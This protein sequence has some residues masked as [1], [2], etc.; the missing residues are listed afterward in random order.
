MSF[1]EYKKTF[2]DKNCTLLITL[3]E[4]DQIKNKK[5]IKLNIISSCGHN[6]SVHY[7]VFK[8]RN[9]GVLCPS[10]KGK[11]TVEKKKKNNEFDKIDGCSRN[12]VT[13]YNGYLMFKEMINELYYIKKTFD[14]CIV[15]F[16]IK[17]K[18]LT[19]INGYLFK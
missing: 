5:N 19:K 4:F 10:C 17:K 8:H 11:E 7:N 14:G 6:H 15:D 18:M 1:E 13:E 9:S 12:N 16:C 2:E 3:E